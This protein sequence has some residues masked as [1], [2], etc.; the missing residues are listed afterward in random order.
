ML[1]VAGKP[2]TTVNHSAISTEYV[3]TLCQL[4]AVEVINVFMFVNTQVEESFFPVKLA[5]LAHA[6]L[7]EPFIR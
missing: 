3:I 4:S 5:R 7:P 6:R 1:G 2:R